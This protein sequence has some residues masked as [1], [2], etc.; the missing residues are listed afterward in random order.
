MEDRGGL[1]PLLHHHAQYRLRPERKRRL[2]WL[3][4]LDLELLVVVQ[5]VDEPLV[6]FMAC[7]EAVGGREPERHLGGRLVRVGVLA[8]DGEAGCDVE[9][10]KAVLPGRPAEGCELRPP[11][12]RPARPL[13]EFVCH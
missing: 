3:I 10:K 9:R 12:R 8:A 1:D 13:G 5:H 7:G 4:R 11:P 2:T 6:G